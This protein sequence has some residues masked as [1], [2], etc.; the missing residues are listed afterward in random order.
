MLELKQQLRSVATESHKG[1]V[2]KRESNELIWMRGHPDLRDSDQGVRPRGEPTLQG[3]VLDGNRIFF[4]MPSTRSLHNAMT[5]AL[6][7]PGAAPEHGCRSTTPL[8]SGVQ[9]PRARAEMNN[10]SRHIGCP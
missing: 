7:G 4:K 2:D 1:M 5:V 8:A 3:S 10:K 6:A 9:E